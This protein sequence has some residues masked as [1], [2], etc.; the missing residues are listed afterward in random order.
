MYFLNA[1]KDA[2]QLTEIFVFVTLIFMKDF[3]DEKAEC[4]SVSISYHQI[5]QPGFL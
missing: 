5:L 3:L 1:V 4:I 2:I